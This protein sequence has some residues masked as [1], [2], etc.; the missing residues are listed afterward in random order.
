MKR[1]APGKADPSVNAIRLRIRNERV[2]DEAANPTHT[3][4]NALS[5]KLTA[6]TKSLN[7]LTEYLTGQQG[8]GENGN[9][10]S[11]SNSKSGNVSTFTFV[12]YD[13]TYDATLK[14]T[15]PETGVIQVSLSVYI[16]LRVNAFISS[17]VTAYGVN[18]RGGIAF[19][20]IDKNGVILPGYPKHSDTATATI[21]V[22]GTNAA[23]VAGA[24]Y[25]NITRA[26]DLTPGMEY[27]LRTRRGRYGYAHDG[28]SNPISM[29]DGGWW[30]VD[31]GQPKA[32]VT[33]VAGGSDDVVDPDES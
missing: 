2:K 11:D 31:I 14:F 27:T 28:N 13:P 21:E 18:A 10:W 6:L 19:D 12:P 1:Y 9:S 32:S 20:L 8:Y 17:G 5:D 25:S 22:W 24:T 16:Y 7:T 15:A 23:N 30:T 4:T 3:E 33:L 29:P 26:R